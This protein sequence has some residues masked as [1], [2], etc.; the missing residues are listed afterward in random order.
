MGS[1]AVVATIE[2][3]VLSLRFVLRPFLRRLTLT[4]GFKKRSLITQMET[5]FAGGSGNSHMNAWMCMYV[6]CIH[7][8]VYIYI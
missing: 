8:A 4:E 1:A 3:Q 2:L 6:T 5:E 7:M